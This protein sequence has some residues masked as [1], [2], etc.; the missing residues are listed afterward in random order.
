MD[1]SSEQSGGIDTVLATAIGIDRTV[2]ADVGGII[3]GDDRPRLLELHTVLNGGSSSSV[4]QPSS[5][6]WR[7]VGSKRPVGLIPAPRPRR[8]A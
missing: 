1:L 6:S 5:K 7:V 8:R 4:V 2:E 3:A